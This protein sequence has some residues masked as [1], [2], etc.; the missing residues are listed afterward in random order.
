MPYIILLCSSNFFL[1]DTHHWCNGYHNRPE[2]NRLWVK[3]RSGQTKDYRIGICYFS[4]KHTVL[5]SINWASSSHRT[6]SRHDIA[7]K[8]PIWH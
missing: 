5:S 8:L 3:P 1:K 7:E 6:C 2:S 4:A